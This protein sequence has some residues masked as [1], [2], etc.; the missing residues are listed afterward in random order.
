MSPQANKTDTAQAATER[1]RELNE[2]ILD[3][4]RNAGL[5]YLEV[6]ESTLKTFADYQEQ[7]GGAVPVESLA[8]IAKAQANFT[9]DVVTAYA[10]NARNL[11]K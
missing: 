3:Y 10:Q 5:A 11:L 7:V 6:Y 1:I 2:R 9:R 4:G 8:S